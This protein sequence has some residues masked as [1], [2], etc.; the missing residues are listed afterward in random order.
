VGDVIGRNGRY[1]T[2]PTRPM[3]SE[4]PDSVT[5]AEFFINYDTGKDT[6]PGTHAEP[7]KT[8]QGLQD[9]IGDNYPTLLGA[10]VATPFPHKQTVIHLETDF[11]E[12]APFVIRAT[13]PNN[14]LLAI[15]G[16]LTTLHSGSLTDVTPIDRTTSQS[17]EVTDAALVG[18][19]AP[20]VGMSLR[21]TSGPNEGQIFWIDE[22]LGG[23]VAS[24][25]APNDASSSDFPASLI[26]PIPTQG[27]VE[28]G[29]AYAIEKCSNIYFRDVDVRGGYLPALSFANLNV[30]GPPLGTGLPPIPIVSKTTNELEVSYCRCSFQTLL[31][32]EG[33]GQTKVTNCLFTNT[34]PFSLQAV[35][36]YLVT[37]FGGGCVGSPV[38]ATPGGSLLLDM[39][40]K[41]KSTFVSASGGNV[42]LGTCGIYNSPSSGVEIGGYT[43]GAVGIVWAVPFYAGES[44]VYG[45]GNAAA[46]VSVG[47]GSSLVYGESAGAFGTTT[48]TVTGAVGDFV[49]DGATTGRAWDE[50][51]GAYGGAINCTWSNLV[52]AQP[53][54]FGGYAHNVQSNAH[55]LF[56][57]SLL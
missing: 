35:G 3:R 37:A 13:V 46:G 11:P 6:N 41:I 27:I 34:G 55:V 51:G 50:S 24:I 9:L 52:A 20:Y 2:Y 23:G 12:E 15:V 7:L 48:F 57:D 54:G 40:Y 30:V 42:L 14:S 17:W 33:G 26:I 19:W 39:D 1:A 56:G 38:N 22:D 8:P 31:V 44:F 10:D 4:E 32:C 5:Q 47:P 21:I 16:T 43:F 49:L 25:T 53:G 29:D 36:G 18:G 28:L 45:D